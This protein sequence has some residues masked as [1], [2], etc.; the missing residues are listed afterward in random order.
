MWSSGRGPRRG[1][2]DA[3]ATR[4]YAVMT[5]RPQPDPGT[6]D[7]RTRDIRL[8][9]LPDRPPSMLPQAWADAR[10]APGDGAAGAPHCSA[11]P[12]ARPTPQP[13]ARAGTDEAPPAEPDEPAGNTRV[14]TP[15][16]HPTDQLAP[17]VR[18]RQR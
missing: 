7:E 2:D 11:P 1:E 10:Q 8:S 6:Y 16:E 3:A 13:E 17:P 12:P 5:D 15:D 9:P 4:R 14:P 18:R